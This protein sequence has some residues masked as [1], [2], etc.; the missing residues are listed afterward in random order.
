MATKSFQ[1]SFYLLSQ[2]LND[3]VY[4]FKIIFQ[5]IDA[6]SRAGLYRGFGKIGIYMCVDTCCIT[7]GLFFSAF[8]NT[9]T[10]A[11]P[12]VNLSWYPAMPGG[13]NLQN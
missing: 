2:R 5:A 6:L 8:M 9:C 10:H 7:T 12:V 3:V 13:K 4:F 11:L 1:G